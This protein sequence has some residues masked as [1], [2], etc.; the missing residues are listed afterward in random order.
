MEQFILSPVMG[1]WYGNTHCQGTEG[2]HLPPVTSMVEVEP[3]TD[4]YNDRIPMHAYVQ[5]MGRKK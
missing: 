3:H 5:V 2:E 1:I 4:S